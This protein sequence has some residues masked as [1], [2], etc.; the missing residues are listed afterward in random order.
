MAGH[1]AWTKTLYGHK[2]VIICFFQNAHKNTAIEHTAANPSHRPA[3]A[4]SRCEKEPVAYH[5]LL[6]SCS[7]TTGLPCY[8][9]VN[10]VGGFFFKIRVENM[11]M[12]TVR[13]LCVDPS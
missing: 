10:K 1:K 6:T 9:W 3:S 7:T 8:C 4:G 11:S 13:L 2:I 12:S 5:D